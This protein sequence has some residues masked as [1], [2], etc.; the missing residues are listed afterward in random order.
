MEYSLGSSRCSD[1]IDY[2]SE[3]D[4]ILKLK[5]GDQ[6]NF[7]LIVDK[8]KSKIIRL[9]WSYT[10]DEHEAEDLSQEVFISFYKSIKDFREECSLSTF[11]IQNKCFEMF[12]L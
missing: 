5:Q 4:I 12:I 3:H 10:Y 7:M 11:F 8:Y 1:S 2:N 6:K 9:C